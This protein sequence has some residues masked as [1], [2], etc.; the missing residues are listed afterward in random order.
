MLEEFSNIWRS[1]RATNEKRIDMVVQIMYELVNDGMIRIQHVQDFS[2][3]QLAMSD[4]FNQTVSHIISE[5]GDEF[6]SA[7][8]NLN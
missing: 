8:E 6:V 3:T 1:L 7:A 2:S 5:D 4:G